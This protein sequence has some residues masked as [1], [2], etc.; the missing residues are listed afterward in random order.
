MVRI[1]DVQIQAAAR[2]FAASGWRGDAVRDD[3][4]LLPDDAPALFPVFLKL[5]DRHCLAVGGG[6]VAEPR[7]E[8]LLA[9]KANVLVIAPKVTSNVQQWAKEK[10]LLW[11]ERPFELHDLNGMGLVIC[12]TSSAAD[13][14]CGL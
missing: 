14:S 11:E 5:A 13:Q 6:K 9:A 2:T 1:H 4:A 3:L 12:A 7:I 10:R 8:S